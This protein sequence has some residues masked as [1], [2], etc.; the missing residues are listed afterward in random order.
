VVQLSTLGG[1]THHTDFMSS[2]EYQCCFCGLSVVRLGDD[3]V[4]LTLAVEGG[5]SQ[6]LYCHAVCL[7]RVLHPSV[8]VA[9]ALDDPKI[10]D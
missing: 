8:P 2:P 9:L 4:T 1:K 7:C 3:P 5:A 10:A 6:T